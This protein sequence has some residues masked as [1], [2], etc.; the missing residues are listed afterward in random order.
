MEEP[1]TS[2]LHAV[3]FGVE[4][5]I[6]DP[7]IDPNNTRMCDAVNYAAQYLTTSERDLPQRNSR[8]LHVILIVTDNMSL[9]S[10]LHDADVLFDLYRYAW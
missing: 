8:R 7:K 4:R 2:D 5:A 9:K 10:E 3:E 1:L 6:T